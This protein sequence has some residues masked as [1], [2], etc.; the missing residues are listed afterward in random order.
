[1]TRWVDGKLHI[2]YRDSLQDTVAIRAMLAAEEPIAA[3]CS[4]RRVWGGLTSDTRLIDAVRG[5]YGAMNRWLASRLDTSRR[6]N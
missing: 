4:D 5:A 1:L 2:D 6:V 3:F